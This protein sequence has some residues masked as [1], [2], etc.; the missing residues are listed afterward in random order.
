M[1]C[2]GWPGRRSRGNDR[3]RPGTPRQ[4]D[5]RL[6]HPASGSRDRHTV[7]G[8]ACGFDAAAATDEARE[9]EKTLNDSRS[10]Q[11]TS[12]ARLHTLA[13][14]AVKEGIELNQMPGAGH[15]IATNPRK[16]S[17]YTLVVLDDGSVTCNCPAGRNGIPCKH[18]A[19]LMRYL[20][21]LPPLP[22]P[23]P[24]PVES[25]PDPT[26]LFPDRPIPDG[27]EC[28]EWRQLT[29]QWHPAVLA[30]HEDEAR[31]RRKVAGE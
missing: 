24:G 2:C 15:W 27:W 13:E 11:T 20:G 9:S 4:R 5:T 8:C 21:T 17:R 30:E 7:P 31:A 28:P 6:L 12:L 16:G 25:K 18:R 1:Q 26:E 22:P 19:L 3:R 10:F 23:E 14:R 29:E